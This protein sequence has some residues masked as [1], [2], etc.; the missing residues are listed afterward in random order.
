[1]I[2][3]L[4]ARPPNAA[5]D[6]PVPLQEEKVFSFRR[7]PMLS[8][9]VPYPA[10]RLTQGDPF[11]AVFDHFPALRNRF[12]GEDSITVHTGPAQAQGE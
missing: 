1:M 8:V 4:R 7:P 6:N 5:V 3:K 9:V 2:D 12:P 11:S 10:I